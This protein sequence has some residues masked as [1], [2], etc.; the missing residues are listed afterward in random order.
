[1]N[2]SPWGHLVMNLDIVSFHNWQNATVLGTVG[3]GLHAAKCPMASRIAHQDSVPQNINS[4]ETDF[5]VLELC[6]LP[7]E[8]V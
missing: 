8:R 1:M 7:R 5:L 4:A 2:V 3:R 6:E